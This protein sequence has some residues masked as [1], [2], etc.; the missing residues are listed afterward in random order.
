M[1][2]TNLYPVLLIFAIT[3]GFTG[4]AQDTLRLSLPAAEQLFLQNNLSLLAQKYNISIARAGIIQAGLYN[5]PSVQFDGNIYNPELKKPFD[6]SNRTGQYGFEVNQLIYLA[7]K[8]NKQIKVAQANAAIAESNFFDVLRTLSYSLRSD[9]HA[10][11]FLQNSISGYGLQIRYLEKLNAAYQDLQGKGIVT[12]KDAVRIKSLLYTLK[13][14]QTSLQNQVNDLNAEL[15]LLIRN[16]SAYI[17]PVADSL[18]KNFNPASYN[19][20][21]LVDSAMANRSD[22][23][24]AQ[25]NMVYNEQNYRLQKAMAVPDLN[26]GAYFDKRGNFVTNATFFT[27]GMDLPVF[28]RNQGNIKIAQIEIDQAKTQYDLQQQTVQ[29]EVQT[30]YIK[31]LNTNKVISSFD[32]SFLSQLDALLQSVT[33]NFQK[34]NISIIEFTDFYESYKDNILQFNQLKNERVQAI[35]ALQFSI[36]KQIFN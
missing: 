8:R 17:I 7:G 31:A 11:F 19:L 22:L 16:N 23:K 25:Q 5:N 4:K 29:N 12:L 36:G 27:V 10:L 14:E 26:L 6:M 9:F 1:R 34:K 30:A 24:A 21:A 28:N 2:I 15:Q 18:T 20:A 33:G 3:V 13:A 32:Q 35:E